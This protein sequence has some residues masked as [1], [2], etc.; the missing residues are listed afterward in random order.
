MTTSRATEVSEATADV[1]GMRV[2]VVTMGEAVD[3]VGELLNRESPSLVVTPNLDHLLRYR[4]SPRFQALYD[5]AALVLADGAPIVWMSALL[6]D[7]PTLPGRVT[8][9]DLLWDVVKAHGLRAG[10]FIVGSTEEACASFAGRVHAELG[11]IPVTHTSPM[12]DQLSDAEV[13]ELARRVEATGAGI[14]ALALGSPKQEEFFL[15]LR[16]HLS[17]GVCIGCGAAVDLLSGR[18]RRAPLLMQELGFEWL[19]RLIQEPRRMWRRYL[20]D[21]LMFLP[22]LLQ[23]VLARATRFVRRRAAAARRALRRPEP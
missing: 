23:L 7:E 5:E 4:Q 1:L 22:L 9:V 10:V 21:G 16:P 18:F 12:V 17:R 2:R 19:F 13:E 11:P 20:A 14:I 6:P 15:R 8:G 3:L